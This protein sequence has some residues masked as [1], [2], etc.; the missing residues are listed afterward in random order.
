MRDYPA[1]AFIRFFDNHGLLKINNRPAW[2]TVR[3]GSQDYVSRLIADGR[4]AVVT[5][6]R[7]MPAFTAA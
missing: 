6:A 4:F 5:G 3:G 2:R 1:R 7:R